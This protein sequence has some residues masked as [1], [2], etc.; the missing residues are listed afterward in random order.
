MN[1]M[2]DNLDRGKYIKTVHHSESV[3]EIYINKELQQVTEV[4]GLNYNRYKEY[5][6]T[7]KEYLSKL[8]GFK[9]VDK[10]LLVAIETK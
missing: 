10:S 9:K 6:Y 5:K 2:K 3:V 8:G 1:N 7:V 4:K